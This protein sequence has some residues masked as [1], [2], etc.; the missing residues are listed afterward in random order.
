MDK[1]ITIEIFNKLGYDDKV[2]MNETIKCYGDLFENVFELLDVPK[3]MTDEQ[4]QRY[5][6]L[7][8]LNCR[9]CQNITDLGIRELKFLKKLNCCGCKNITDESIINLTHLKSLVCNG[10]EKITDKSIQHLKKLKIINCDCY[11]IDST[12]IDEIKDR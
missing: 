6:N 3:G 8:S 5:K 10:C 1:Y 7:T 12:I 9:K 4:L 2:L 11:K